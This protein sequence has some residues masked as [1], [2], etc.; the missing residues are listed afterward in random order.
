M[1]LEY[2]QATTLPVGKI[3]DQRDAVMRANHAA[4]LDAMA[5]NFQQMLEDFVMVSVIPHC[6]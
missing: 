6:F 4:G 3:H 1:D 2:V 5:G